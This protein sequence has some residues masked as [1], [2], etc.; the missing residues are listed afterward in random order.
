MKLQWFN[1]H[2]TSKRLRVTAPGR[3][4]PVVTSKE[5][6]SVR[7]TLLPD[8]DAKGDGVHPKNRRTPSPLIFEL[9]RSA[10]CSLT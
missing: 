4:L 7:P 9:G 3:F 2:I 5:Q 8:L 10:G 6:V 1:R